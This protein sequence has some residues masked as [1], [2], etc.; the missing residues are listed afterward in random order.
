MKKRYEKRVPKL[1]TATTDELF[2]ELIKRLQEDNQ[3]H[4]YFVDRTTLYPKWSIYH[5]N[6]EGSEQT[7]NTVAKEI[8]K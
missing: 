1:E 6:P 8:V 3:H 5:V 2:T 7:Y 4:C